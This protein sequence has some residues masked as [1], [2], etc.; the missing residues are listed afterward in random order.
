MLKFLSKLKGTL[1]LTISR[2]EETRST[3]F[4]FI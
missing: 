3:R 1:T 4:K 2:Q